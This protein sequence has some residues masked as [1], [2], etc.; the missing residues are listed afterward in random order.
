MARPAGLLL[1]PTLL[2]QTGIH[3][4]L[5]HFPATGGLSLRETVGVSCVPVGVG[6]WVHPVG[7]AT[8]CNRHRA[9]NGDKS[10]HHHTFAYRQS[11]YRR[12]HFAVNRLQGEALL[13]FGLGLGS[14]GEDDADLDF[15]RGVCEFALD[16]TLGA[17]FA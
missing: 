3:D 5:V 8:H 1:N 2:F 4:L 13:V 10:P 6:I 11:V 17:A 14:G 9:Q 7:R 16:A 12:P 15:A